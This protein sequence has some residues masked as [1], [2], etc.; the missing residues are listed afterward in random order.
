[1]KCRFVFL[2]LGVSLPTVLAAFRKTERKFGGA[3]RLGV[4][5]R[6]GFVIVDVTV[7]MVV[8]GL[9]NVFVV[10]ETLFTVT[11]VKFPFAC[12]RIWA[13]SGDI[14]SSDKD[15]KLGVTVEVGF[16]E[17]KDASGIVEL[18]LFTDDSWFDTDEEA[19]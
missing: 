14:L 4:D 18:L 9:I 10:V 5:V 15:E 3:G 7:V 12:A 17:A 1:M 11:D 13:T 16:V 2:P 8:D 19:F 6:V